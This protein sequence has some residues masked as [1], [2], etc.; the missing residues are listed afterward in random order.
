MWLEWRRAML[1]FLAIVPITAVGIPLH[2][3][4]IDDE[5]NGAEAYD[6]SKSSVPGL[7]GSETYEI[8]GMNSMSSLEFEFDGR[9]DG[10]YIDMANIEI[11]GSLGVGQSFRTRNIK[12]PKQRTSSSRSD[13][14]SVTENTT[15]KHHGAALKGSISIQSEFAYINR[16]QD[17]LDHG[18]AILLVFVLCVL[19]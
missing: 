17:R 16:L 1:G 8:G 4:S 10:D 13:F 18:R 5:S 19:V 6:S 11:N 7:F 3:D 9:F 15:N 2:V 14:R 12:R